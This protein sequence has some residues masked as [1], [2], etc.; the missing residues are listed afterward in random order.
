[1]SKEE[2]MEWISVDERLPEVGDHVLIWAGD[3]KPSIGYRVN[4]GL[5]YSRMAG[6][7][8][9]AF[10]GVKHWMPLPEAPK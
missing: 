6:E 8:G 4:T 5:W 9:E 7:D 1:V 10:W 3:V 2:K